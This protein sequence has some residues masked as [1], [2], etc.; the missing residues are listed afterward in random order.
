MAEV[1]G[2]EV[3]RGQVRVYIDGSEALRVKK[4]HFEKCPLHEGDETDI[5][6]YIERLAA[7]Q[8]A[9]AW[10]AALSSLDV[11]ARSE[12]E[13]A[14][15]LKRRGFV[16]P[17]IDATVSRLRESGLIDDARYAQRMAELQSRKPVGL[18]A[19]K[20][21]LRAKGISDADAEDALSAFDDT[22]QQAAC[23][24][25]AGKLYKKYEALPPREGKAKM[26]QALARR[27]FGWEAIEAALDGL[28]D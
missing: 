2:I 6:A 12:R 1:T 20:R 7:V 19:F 5:D 27:G 8:C 14:N 17:A 18:Y 26:S 25:A 15:S 28:F 9:D 23:A 4:A 11:C 24:E 21:R 3:L 10:E 22:Q 16:Q 13:I